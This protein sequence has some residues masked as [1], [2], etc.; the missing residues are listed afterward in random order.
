M[1]TFHM[2]VRDVLDV[3]IM[4]HAKRLTDTHTGPEMS[5]RGSASC[6]TGCKGLYDTTKNMFSG[7]I[8]PRISCTQ[9]HQT[10]TY[11]MWLSLATK[12]FWADMKVKRFSSFCSHHELLKTERNSWWHKTTCFIRSIALKRVFTATVFFIGQ[13]CTESLTIFIGS[14]H[15]KI[16]P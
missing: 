2:H 8:G 7:I 13:E 12:W 5:S 14:F 15:H 6:C 10:C 3:G 11:Q 9:T 4:Q 16:M 1:E